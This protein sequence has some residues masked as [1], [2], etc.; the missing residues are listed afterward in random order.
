MAVLPGAEEID[1]ALDRA[2]K[3]LTAETAQPVDRVVAAATLVAEWRTILRHA[4]NQ[5]DVELAVLAAKEWT[6]WRGVFC[7]LTGDS[8]PP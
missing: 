3:A 4:L 8:L 1:V 5:N 2:E 7:S 6:H